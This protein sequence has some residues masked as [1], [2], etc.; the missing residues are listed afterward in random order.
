[1]KVS[2]IF[3]KV[4]LMWTFLCI[5][6]T[7]IMGADK[8]KNTFAT[9]D[10]AFPKTVSANARP[11]LEKSLRQ[12][13]GPMAL[14]ALIEIVVA[15]NLI[16]EENAQS[17]AA[18]I[19]SIA[20][21]LETPYSELAYLLEG[22]LYKEIYSEAPYLYNRRS[23]PVTPVPADVKEWSRDIFSNKICGLTAKGLSN[24]EAAKN[25]PIS[26]ISNFVENISDAESAGLTV[27]DFMTIG[28][29]ENLQPFKNSSVEIPFYSAEGKGDRRTEMNA[30]ALSNSIVSA[31]LEWH[32]EKYDLHSASVMDLYA[33]ETGYIVNGKEEIIK[34]VKKYEDTPYCADFL[35]R[36]KN[37]Y[38]YRDNAGYQQF[39]N[40]VR[41]YTDRFPDCR[42]ASSLAA[43]LKGMTEVRV[44][45]TVPVQVL[46]GERIKGSAS[47]SN[48]GKVYVLMVKVDDSLLGNYVPLNQAENGKV[49]AAVPVESKRMGETPFYD[50]LP[51]EIESQNPGVYALMASTTPDKK[52]IIRNVY[53]DSRIPLMSVSRLGILTSTD[54][55][56]PAGKGQVLYVVEGK[57]Q[58]PVAGAKV[59]FK[60]SWKNSKW[61]TVVLTTD[62]EGAV[63]VPEGSYNVTVVL[64]KDILKGQVYSSGG[65]STPKQMKDGSLFTDLSIYHPG[66]SVGFTGVVFT[67]KG[68]TL[69][70][71][72]GREIKVSLEDVNYQ[73]KASIKLITDK[74]GRINGKFALP[75]DGL[76]G[77]WSL[78]MQDENNYLC[79]T[80]FVVSDYK[81]P[82]FYVTTTGTEGEVKLGEVVK[83]K[84]EVKTYSGMPVGGAV[85]KYDVNF[86]PWYRYGV[87]NVGNASYGG[88]TTASSDGSF[89]IELPTARLKDTPYAFGSFRLN[90][91][92]TN[93]VGE[94]QQGSP[95]SFSLGEAYEIMA[96]IPSYI[97]VENG[98]KVD[99]TVS[100]VDMF[101]YPVKKTIHY[102]LTNV[103][104][105]LVVAEGECQPGKF[106]YKFMNLK[107]GEYK[108]EFSLVSFSNSPERDLTVDTGDEI[109]EDEISVSKFIVW[110]SEEKC[111]PVKTE[112]WLPETQRVLTDREM[113]D[114]KVRIS[115]GTSYPDSYI[116]AEIA[117][118][119]GVKERKWLHVKENMIEIPV[120]TPNPEGRVRIT[121]VGMHD[122]KS[123]ERSLTLIPEIQTKGLDIKTVTFRDK[124]TPGAKEEWRFKFTFNNESLASLPVMAVM[125]NKA[126]DALEPFSWVFNPYGSLYWSIPGDIGSWGVRNQTWNYRPESNPG[127]SLQRYLYPDWNTY[128]ESL[129]GGGNRRINSMSIRGTRMM[130]AAKTEDTLEE[131]AYDMAYSGGMVEMAAAA[132]INSEMKADGGEL[133]ESGVTAGQSA[134]DNDLSESDVLREVECPLAFFMPELETDKDGMAALD[135]TV[136]AFNGSWSLQVMGYTKDMRGSVLRKEAISSKPVMVQMNAPRFARTG[137]RLSVSANIYNNRSERA[138]LSGKIEIVNPLT[139]EA[140]LCEEYNGVETE[141]SGSRTITIMWNV[142]SDIEG[143]VVRVFGYS[144]GNSDGEQVRIPIYPSSTPVVESET[145]YLAP[146]ESNYSV[147][148]PSDKKNATMT[149]NY[150]D[151]PIWECVTSL[152]SIMS[153]DS[154]SAL[155]QATAL[156]GNAMT[157]GLIGKYPQIREALRI[158]ASEE[159][160]GD[161]TL[162]SNLQKNASL[163]I[164]TLNNTPWVR[165]ADADT[166][167]MASLADYLDESRAKQEIEKCIDK[168]RSL[169]SPAGGWSWCEDMPAS[170]W[171]TSSV[172]ANMALLAESGFLPEEARKMADK[173]IAFVESEIVKDW[174]KTGEKK[175][176]YQSLLSY[177]YVR[178]SF[179][180]VPMKRDF[181]IIKERALKEIE[182]SWK[183]MDIYDKATAALV[184]DRNGRK[185]VSKEILSSLEE[186][187]SS[188]KEKGIWFDN[189]KSGFYGQGK[190][191]T[192]ARALQAWKE[193]DPTS[194]MVDGLRQWML[195]SKQVEDWGMCNSSALLVNSIY[196]TGSDWNGNAAEPEIYLDDRKLEL[197]RI[198]KLTGSLTLPLT[199][200]KGILRI[201][202]HAD[203]PAWGGIISQFVAPIEEVKSESVPQLSV[204]KNMYVITNSENGT[205]ASSGSLK[206]GDRV[207]VTLT[208][209]N[210]RDLEYLAVTDSRS[211]ALE[212]AEQV[213]GYTSTDG[214][215]YYK[216]V[217]N[218]STNLFIPFLPKGTHILSYDCF[219]DR[220]GEYTLGIAEAQSQYAPVITAHSAG[221]LIKIGE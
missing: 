204:E 147:S 172:L 57:N 182:R 33:L 58:R 45:I 91:S 141:A 174:Q 215:W 75:N 152:P 68:Q 158:Y 64:G 118:M 121:F 43:L 36:L 169:Q 168:L 56:A 217:R 214:V 124:L 96:H 11:M 156:Y 105:S 95:V 67:R 51:F 218:S 39:Y 94:T 90:I 81:S 155:V 160:L 203:G 108:I 193:I 206:P 145:F 17:G 27:Y 22:R 97:K 205:T 142:P 114:K 66:D 164:V 26:T 92:A 106:D 163:K 5:G 110:R 62:S 14:Q 177:L 175:Y 220:E 173:G 153:T 219:V 18:L 25:L 162:I 21:E 188:S 120:S 103:A 161:S 86:I 130:K 128:G 70:V 50:H 52:G 146:G 197:P 194:K 42:G 186:Y 60:P 63:K 112:L 202:R 69:E 80:N 77:Y 93:Q 85:V 4:C 126:L 46:P 192:T 79:Q 30:G 9:P 74:Y 132:P 201:V 98:G 179:K 129:Y 24:T 49:T 87:R 191:L 131:V 135:F 41:K 190:L 55:R 149:L 136:P 32:K 154:E 157:S 84:G 198:A 183:K 212:P 143:A 144:G 38:E 213:S 195:L 19:D 119:S 47:I 8:N 209:K 12:N 44:D 61:T 40:T 176:P 101:G 122:L 83:V 151:N 167:R 71:A 125:T 210:D 196:S 72:A 115:A 10:F 100:V 117:D 170:S 189:L 16:S 113:K 54:N 216:E 89:M 138:E 159:N 221:A 134:Q 133:E 7:G 20:G 123:I 184:L 76:L 65:Y 35:I 109:E 199:G 200:E 211:A 48:I 140:Y 139:G 53:K 13:D 1:M 37:F 137:D 6:T 148:V 178:S 185:S 181:A 111:P 2:K 82:T 73:E 28:A 207:R 187:S 171:I 127:V 31:N 88:E 150:T 3:R 78:K 165:S 107:S 180:N 15:E 104:D 99:A 34:L 116:F 208:I 23:I 29:V 166:R 59:T 102:R